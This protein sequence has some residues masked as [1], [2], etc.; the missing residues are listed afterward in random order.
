MSTTVTLATA[1]PEADVVG[2]P[3]RH[4]GRRGG[5]SGYTVRKLF[6]LFSEL[7]INN[8]SILLRFS[9]YAGLSFSCLAFVVGLFTIYR[10]LH[11]GVAIQGWTSLFAAL[12][13]IGGLLLFSIGVVGE[14]LIRIIESSEGRP[15]YYVRR[16]T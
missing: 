1:A 9:A 8:S 14:Y 7:V 11:H 16:R 15:M 3:V 5:R 12:M 6:R 13:L 2:V 4:N 10:K